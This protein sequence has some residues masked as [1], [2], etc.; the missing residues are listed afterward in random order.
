MNHPEPPVL[1]AGQTG[2]T[3]AFQPHPILRIRSID[4]NEQTGL[5][6]AKEGDHHRPKQIK[7]HQYPAINRLVVSH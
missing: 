2:F 4:Q 5:S 6:D 7:K 3:A 1:P